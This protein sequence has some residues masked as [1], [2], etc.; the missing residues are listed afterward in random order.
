MRAFIW[1]G[2]YQE[3]VPTIRPRDRAQAPY[4]KENQAKRH[5]HIAITKVQKTML[6][7]IWFRFCVWEIYLPSKSRAMISFMTSD[8]PP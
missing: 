3:T 1:V 2:M 5:H 4:D 7:A 6:F 8:A